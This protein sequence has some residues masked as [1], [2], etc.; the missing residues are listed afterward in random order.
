M[1]SSTKREVS[2]EQ[3][4]IKPKQRRSSRLS[5][6]HPGSHSRKSFTSTETKMPKIVKSYSSTEE[7]KLETLYSPNKGGSK[8]IKSHEDSENSN[9]QSK[10][11]YKMSF[12]GSPDLSLG[13]DKLFNA[14]NLCENSKS[15]IISINL[16]NIKNMIH[17]CNM[18]LDELRSSFSRRDLRDSSF[19]DTIITVLCLVKS[20]LNLIK[21]NHGLHEDDVISEHMI[22]T[23]FTEEKEFLSDSNLNRIKRHYMKFYSMYPVEDH[24]N[25]MEFYPDAGGEIPKD[26]PPEKGPRIRM[27]VYVDADHAHDIVTRRSITEMLVIAN[28][29]PIRWIYKRQKTV[30]TSN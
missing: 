15:L 13:I 18:E 23:T 7:P 1:S 24:S 4:E 8:V 14:I 5:K 30:E 26:L 2:C 11:S 6:K 27:I 19:Q 29:M 17:L 9:N 28:N 3:K 10:S 16:C 12:W 20:F 25:W 22:P 21:E